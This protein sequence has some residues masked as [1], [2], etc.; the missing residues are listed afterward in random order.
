MLFLIVAL[1]AL[2]SF[3]ACALTLSLAR[4]HKLR[5]DETVG[6][7]KLHRHWAPRLGGIPIAVAGFSGLMIWG[8]FMRPTYNELATALVVCTLPAFA[9]GLLED[10][11]RRAGVTTRLLVTMLAAAMGFWLLDA[12]MISVA[13]PWLDEWLATTPI[14]AL[15]LTLVAVGGVSHATNIVD[16]CNGLA[17]GVAVLVLTAIAAIAGQVGDT[18]IMATS[19]IT[20]AATVGFFAWNFP[21]G[22]IFLGDSGAYTLGY[23][24]ATL[25]LMLVVR[26]PEVSPW[27]PLLLMIYPI[28]ETLFSVGRRAASGLR[29]VSQPDALHLHQLVLRRLIRRYGA[30]PVG[31]QRILRN[32]IASVYLWALT[33]LCVVPALIWWRS[34]PV[35]MLLVILFTVTY[36]TFYRRLVAFRA[37]RFLVLDS[38]SRAAS[39]SLK[40]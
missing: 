5:G 11:T 39:A 38:I 24:I 25:S 30:H 36:T 29:G 1:S 31:E 23:L 2:V 9:I 12:R 33:L 8:W 37:P 7:Q 28:W 21:F 3:G 22:R 34:T 4:K 14:G 15:A 13:I 19:L 20:V 6:R 27:C 26:N 35:M 10:V 32:S 16:G 18:F 40:S 17:S